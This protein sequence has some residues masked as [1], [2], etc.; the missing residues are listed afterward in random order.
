ML[1]NEKGNM[2]EAYLAF[3]AG[4]EE[5][6]K[7]VDDQLQKQ[8]GFSA[9]IVPET[10]GQWIVVVTH[11]GEDGVASAH[12]VARRFGIYQPR[13]PT[14]RISRGRKHESMRPMYP[15]Y[16]FAYV[17][18][19]GRHARR[20]LSCPGVARLLCKEDGLTPVKVPWPVINLIREQENRENP[21]TIVLDDV[22]GRTRKRPRKNKKAR[23]KEILLQG[24]TL[25]VNESDL[26]V[27]ATYSW[28][29]S[30]ERGNWDD[31]QA[32]SALHKALGLAA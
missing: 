12:M 9:E 16:I 31:V 17:W 18:D 6:L 23:R 3:R 13:I 25:T 28:G 4:D 5:R 32:V 30:K 19:I 8:G 1:A 24:A 22:I 10:E 7:F 15:N 29:F 27:V 20:I 26:D 11:P 2:R 21:L 14:V